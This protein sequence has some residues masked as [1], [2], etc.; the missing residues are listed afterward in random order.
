[1]LHTG[2]CRCGAV[3]VAFET[4]APIERWSTRAC[5]CSFCRQH[6]SVAV[7]DPRGRLTI[8]GG[9]GALSRHRFGLK[10]ADFVLC[11]RCGVFVA[12]VMDDAYATLN[13][14]VLDDAA[15]L[16]APTSVSY[17]GETSDDRIARRRARWT[18]ARIEI[19]RAK[20][21]KTYM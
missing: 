8:R 19:S 6:D 13:A 2:R 20:E 18:P 17:D 11:S 7:T 10:T 5:S 1:M 21:N 16:P 4:D 12:A 14:L 3:E 9:E 15:R